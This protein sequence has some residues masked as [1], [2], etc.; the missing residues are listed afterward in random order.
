MNV[1]QTDTETVPG[2]VVQAINKIAMQHPDRR[3][4]AH[5]VLDDARNEDSPL[6]SYFEWDDS[7]AAERFR[8]NQAR[9]L[10]M[11]AKVCMVAG[12]KKFN[13]R[14][15]VSLGADRIDGGGYRPIGD[16]MSDAERRA[17][18]LRTALSELGNFKKRYETL[19]ELS[20]VWH[21]I[22]EVSA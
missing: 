9:A 21:A 17:E 8:L 3:A 20:G 6:H 16:V 5:A 15:F 4:T 22:D 11:H 18:L 12:E 14:A 2:E 10:I 13:V 7:K 1:V 19:G